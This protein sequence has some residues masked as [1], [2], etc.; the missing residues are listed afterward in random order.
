[1][2]SQRQTRPLEVLSGLK[3]IIYALFDI[4]ELHGDKKHAALLSERGV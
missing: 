2:S 4:K 3:N 1:V